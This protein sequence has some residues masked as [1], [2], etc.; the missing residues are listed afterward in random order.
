VDAPGGVD[1]PKW[2]GFEIMG[3]VLKG[4]EAYVVQAIRAALAAVG[5]G[6]D[7]EFQALARGRALKALLFLN[8]PLDDQQKQWLA[9]DK[10]RRF[11][12]QG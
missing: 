6:E 10:T 4:G 9:D 11:Q 8:V 2:A 7:V 3:E 5:P 12:L 1:W